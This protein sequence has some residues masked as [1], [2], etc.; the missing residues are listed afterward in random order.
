MPV[1]LA[2][3]N[4]QNHE[5]QNLGA[6]DSFPALCVAILRFSESKS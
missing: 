2:S 1:K 5:A 4:A 6:N 3:K